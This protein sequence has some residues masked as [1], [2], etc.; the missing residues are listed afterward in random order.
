MYLYKG[1]QNTCDWK[2]AMKNVIILD[3]LSLLQVLVLMDFNNILQMSQCSNAFCAF[4]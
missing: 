2:Y 1:Q 3:G 4:G